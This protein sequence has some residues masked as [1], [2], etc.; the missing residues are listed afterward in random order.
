MKKISIIVCFLFFI[1]VANAQVPA[2]KSTTFVPAYTTP[3]DLFMHM[4]NEVDSRIQN[5]TASNATKSLTKGISQNMTSAQWNP[6][7]WTNN[8]APIDL[9]GVVIWSDFAPPANGGY[10]S[11]F[12]RG[13]VL[14]SPRHMISATHNALELNKKVRFLGKDNQFVERTVKARMA[15]P[16]YTPDGPDVIVY[17]LDSD[18]PSTITHYPI[19]SKEEWKVAFKNEVPDNY[20]DL[21]YTLPI[22][23]IDQE[24]K[25]GVSQMNKVGLY[26]TGTTVSHGAQSDL[27][28]RYSFNEPIVPG[29][30]G[31]PIFVL[32]GGKPVL[33]SSHTNNGGG[34]SYGHYYNTINSYMAQLGGGYK[35]STIDLSGFT[36]G[37]MKPRP[38]ERFSQNFIISPDKTTYGIGDTI[39][40]KAEFTISP[41]WVAWLAV[42]GV[43]KGEVRF[44][45]RDINSAIVS[46]LVAFD[47]TAGPKT[48][49]FEWKSPEGNPTFNGKRFVIDAVVFTETVYETATKDGLRFG[50]ANVPPVVTPIEHTFSTPSKEIILTAEDR[51]GDPLTYTPDKL[52]LTYG[53]LVKTGEGKYTYTLRTPLPTV[54]I[55]DQFSYS[56]NDG[57]LNS[58]RPATVTLNYTLLPPTI[59]KVTVSKTGNGTVMGIGINCGDECTEELPKGTVLALNA[60]QAMGYTFAGWSGACTGMGVCSITVDGNKNVSARF[61]AVPPTMHS[62][63]TVTSGNGTITGTGINCGQDCQGEFTKD[64]TA[65]LTAT[66]DAG[67]AL[68]SWSGACNGTGPCNVVMNANK[69]VGASFAKTNTAPT[70]QLVSVNTNGTPVEFDLTATDAEKDPVTINIGLQPLRGSVA[71][72]ANNK[73]RYTPITPLSASPYTD[74]FNYNATDGKLTSP[75]TRVTINYTPRLFTLT[76]SKTGNGTVMGIGINCGDE[77]SEELV[78]GSTHALN[79]VA[80][81]GYDFAGWSGACTGMGVCNVKMDQNQ[82]VIANFVV[83]NTTPVAQNGSFTISSPGTTANVILN[84][85][86]AQNDPLTFAPS[87]LSTPKGT[88]TRTAEGKYTYTLKTPLPTAS[89]TESF[90]FTATDGK[91]TS[92]PATITINYTLVPPTVYTITVSK[93]GQGTVTATGIACGQ[94]CQGEFTKDTTATLTATPDAGYAFVGWSGACT[95]A[96]CNVVMNAAKAVTATFAVINTAPVAQSATYTAYANT[97]DFGFFATDPQKDT[98]TYTPA[99]L[100]WPYGTLT[101]LQGEGKYRYTVTGRSATTEVTE[102]IEFTASDSKLTSNKGVITINIPKIPKIPTTTTDDDGDGVLNTQDRCPRT[103]SA[104]KTE[105]SAYGCVKPKTSSFDIKTPLQTNL[106][107]ISDFELGKT[108]L[109][110]IKFKNPV[111]LSRETE[112]IDLDANVRISEK[113]VEIKSSNIPELNQPATITLYNITET[114]PRILKDGIE[115][116]P[117]YCVIESFVGGT[118]IFTVTG[119]SVYTIE[120]TPVQTTIEETPVVEKKRRSGGG[121]G[122]GSSRTITTTTNNEELIVMLTAQL[123]ALIAQLNA[124]TA[125]SGGTFTRDLKVGT[126]HPEVITLQ[127][128][129]NSK[130]FIITTTGPGS[131]GNETS[132]YGA[133]TA[134]AVRKFQISKGITSTG[135]IGPRTRAALNAI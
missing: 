95:G 119:F 28:K 90:T 61:T 72:V 53:N 14:I 70:T 92:A 13:G 126:T 65:T 120:E 22:I 56:A 85:S 49:N 27:P 47:I 127:R 74:T 9:T 24:K 10:N 100:V 32:I 4:Q 107:D 106:T 35:L 20:L 60:S 38:T 91:L 124:L 68:T 116:L 117:P 81:M 128:Y 21:R 8:G 134:M 123:N 101:K 59:H 11:H 133:K 31:H 48:V 104:L 121:G 55:K 66:P 110:K 15:I 39:K 84:A 122:G 69:T 103:P 112:Q 18:V 113:E 71:K 25:V 16:P 94:D 105:V 26:N 93:V 45:V 79:A 99:K 102:A 98:L 12:W 80:A 3:R 19:L 111:T 17:V 97:V 64:T 129:L 42:R 130:G 114:N 88:L 76:T 34:P 73:Y 63:F 86:D 40:A 75:A 125:A 5:V 43:T 109:G 78:G 118:L 23:Y 131:P 83:K 51:D 132:Y 29:D 37:E 67:Y 1:S 30:S 2:L 44:S 115:C 57:K 89:F 36:S 135:N 96:T 87:T 82:T 41:A 7:L 77:C 54:S 50:Y 108:N 58:P 33:I 46:Q 6:N 52:T 62:L